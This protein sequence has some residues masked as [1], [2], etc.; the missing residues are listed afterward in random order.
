MSKRRDPKPRRAL[1]ERSADRAALNAHLHLSARAL[2]L[3]EPNLE[4][5]LSHEA[6]AA[7]KPLALAEARAQIGDPSALTRECV[8]ALSELIR[9]VTFK[10]LSELGAQRARYAH[11]Q[12]GDVRL[13]RAWQHPAWSGL[14]LR[15]SAQGIDLMNALC[16]PEGQAG[17]E[18]TRALLRGWDLAW[19]GDLLF[20]LLTYIRCAEGYGAPLGPE[21]HLAFAHSPL[22][23][24]WAP[25][26]ISAQASIT[27]EGLI[28]RLTALCAPTLSSLWP[29]LTRSLALT[30]LR[31]SRAL[32]TTLHTP[33]A[34]QRS[35]VMEHFNGQAALFMALEEVARRQGR[36]DLCLPMLQY[37]KSLHALLHRAKIRPVET[38]EAL[39]SDV[40]HSDREPYT[41]GLIEVMKGP[42]RLAAQAT[43]VHRAHRFDREPSDNLFLSEHQAS[44]SVRCLP[45]YA[46]IINALEPT[47]G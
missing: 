36:R 19:D 15:F 13:G 42:A 31:R 37:F 33:S 6:P 3:F 16:Q 29:W 44:D 4:S 23:R 25:F 1:E 20:H 30:W 43:S 47:V 28:E 24:L 27:Q 17:E 18:A 35:R 12:Q 26:E 41:R 34:D 9:R 5:G 10:W 40:L 39:L 45:F 38:V 2:T 14:K 22:T 11:P 32:W 8:V 7:L 46:E 21:E